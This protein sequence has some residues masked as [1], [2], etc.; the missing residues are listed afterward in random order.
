M[1]V[2]PG[3]TSAVAMLDLEGKLVSVK[4]GK[5]LDITST[6]SGYGV[7]VVIASDKLPVPKRLE[8]LNASLRTRLISPEY[9]PTRKEK[10]EIARGFLLENGKAW[11]NTH[12]KDALVAALIAWNQLKG[13]LLRTDNR[14]RKM[15]ITDPKTIVRV[16]RNMILEKEG[17]HRSLGRLEKQTNQ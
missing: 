2:D 13:V 14:L 4:S 1:G 11:E 3:T 9:N 15:G 12:E 6:V 5:G 8:K 17:V 7:P 16:K 10:A